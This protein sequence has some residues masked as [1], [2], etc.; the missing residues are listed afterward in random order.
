[1]NPKS[2][3]SSRF[4]ERRDE[5][6]PVATRTQLRGENWYNVEIRIRDVSQRGFLAECG[7]QVLIGSHV[8]LDIP[9]IGPVFAQVRWQI[10]GRMGG[11]FQDPISLN[12]CEWTAVKAAPP[13]E[14][15]A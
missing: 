1:M 9:G 10:G 2:D 3:Q 15:A 7:D 4:H 14:A 13:S 5:R 12:Q 11:M 8:S 6:V